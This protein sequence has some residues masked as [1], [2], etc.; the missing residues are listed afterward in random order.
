VLSPDAFAVEGRL[1]KLLAHVAHMR[2]S[3]ACVPNPIGYFDQ[4]GTIQRHPDV[5]DGPPG[6]KAKTVG[7][8][9]AEAHTID[10]MPAKILLSSGGSNVHKMSERHNRGKP[11]NV[12]ILIVDDSAAMRHGIRY[13]L[14][15]HDDWEVCGEA[16][17]GADAIEKYRQ[18]KPDLLVVDV[19]MPVMNGLDASLEILKLSPKSLILLYTSFLTRELIETAHQSGIRGTVSKDCTEL[20]V[21]GVEALLRG[22][23]FSGPAN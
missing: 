2:E 5:H 8:V 6:L 12:R 19:S 17:D 14:E 9:P 7:P 1:K 18:L 13:M 23:E 11:M 10:C 20:L 21:V 22:E 16:A 4:P 15:N 3:A